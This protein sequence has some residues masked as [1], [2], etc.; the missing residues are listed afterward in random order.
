MIRLNF[1]YIP[2]DAETLQCALAEAVQGETDPHSLS[3]DN[4]LRTHS[5]IGPFLGQFSE[6]HITWDSL[7]GVVRNWWPMLLGSEGIPDLVI[8]RILQSVA[9]VGMQRLMPTLRTGFVPADIPAEI[10]A[11]LL[12]EARTDYFG[13]AWT[14]IKHCTEKS[15]NRDEDILKFINERVP[16]G[17]IRILRGRHVPT[18]ELAG[19]VTSLTSRLAYDE[20]LAWKERFRR[21][22]H[23]SID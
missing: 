6:K 5:V 12:L 15:Y 18:A 8:E 7:L 23:L 3:I 11:W 20:Q 22:H 10:Y 21:I 9:F 2:F 14:I 19:I 1:R 17:L 16:D 4:W 13:R